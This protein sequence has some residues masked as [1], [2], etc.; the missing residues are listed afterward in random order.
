MLISTTK[1]S[2]E[3]RWL[4]PAFFLDTYRVVKQVRK[5]GGIVHLRI[6]PISLRTITAW[7]CETDM[8]N[9][10]NSGAHMKAMKQSKSYGEI[11]STSWE[12]DAIPSWSEAIQ[13]LDSIAIK[14]DS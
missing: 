12:A 13:K 8:L 10:R 1:F 6:Q 2:L 11:T 4:Y 5:S 3:S 14:K 7:K 9:F